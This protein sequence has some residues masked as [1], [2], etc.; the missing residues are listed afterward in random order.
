MTMM[1]F[2]RKHDLPY[3][4]TYQTLSYLGRYGIL[5]ETDELDALRVLLESFAR[6]ERAARKKAD[7][8]ADIIKRISKVLG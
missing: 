6:K 4:I 8:Y 7:K 1:E 5:D 3:N 2:T